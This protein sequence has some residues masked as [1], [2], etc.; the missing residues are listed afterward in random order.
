MTTSYTWSFP[1]FCTRPNVGELADVV[2]EVHWRLKAS[3]GTHEAEVYGSVTL[4]P[5]DPETFTDFDALDLTTVT[6]WVSGLLHVPALEARLAAM[7]AEKA[8]PSIVPRSAP[9]A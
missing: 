6:G 1:Q 5:P 3:D 9:W 2:C 4:P 7:L 8:E